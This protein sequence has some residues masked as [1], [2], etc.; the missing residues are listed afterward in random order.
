[1]EQMP[2]LAKRSNGH[3]PAPVA[4]PKD[5]HPRLRS[6]LTASR[7]VGA[8]LLF[9]V[10]PIALTV[11][12]LGFT[13]GG[14][15]FVFDFHGGLYNA[16]HD[17]LLGHSPY[18]P[19]YLAHQAAVK[20]AGGTPPYIDVPVYPPPSLVAAIPF[21]LLP[22]KLAGALFALLS[23]GA[24]VLALRLL[25]VR[26]WRCYG[27]AFASWPVN[28][29]LRLGALTPLLVLGAAFLWRWRG[30]VL[31]AAV[32]AASIVTAKLFPW[33]IAIWLLAT[34]RYRTLALTIVLG[35]G[36][37]IAAWGL[38]G[39]DG[40][41]SYPQMLSDLSFIQRGIGVST[42]AALLSLGIATAAAQAAAAVIAV[43]L[44]VVAWR[45]ARRPDGDRRA[46][47]LTVTA[48][49]IASPNVWPHYL[50]LLFVPI[51]LIS[52]EFSPMW[53]VPLLAWLAPTQ[54]THG[55]VWLIL[56]HLAIEAIVILHLCRPISF[57]TL[58]A[59]RTP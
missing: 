19:G 38:I 32:A 54:Q 6:L 35:A 39:F 58:R 12:M 25:D 4:R 48:A 40:I 49:L 9:A 30:E 55:N 18:H 56:P 37:V 51:A 33:T 5:N 24:V 57:Q 3:A 42:L 28:S 16:A 43:V 22:W 34:R 1:M 17:I 10:I 20:R 15:S 52:R 53:L 21:G 27:A 31:L 47:A 7:R 41:S 8:V 45:V 36:G 29:S 14:P 46:F 26:D 11:G 13:F 44:L 59:I 50:A 23:I 2:I